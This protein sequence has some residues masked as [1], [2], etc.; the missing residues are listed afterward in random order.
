[1]QKIMDKLIAKYLLEDI[2]RITLAVYKE[3]FDEVFKAYCHAQQSNDTTIGMTFKKL[4][5]LALIEI[6]DFFG[7][8]LEEIN[9]TRAMSKENP[10]R[11][12]LWDL[13]YEA[14]EYLY[15]NDY[16]AEILGDERHDKAV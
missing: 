6:V 3:K 16:I 1:M 15:F 14:K 10:F 13:W 4:E 12:V 7:D 11:D 2:K 8:N 9:L 5:E